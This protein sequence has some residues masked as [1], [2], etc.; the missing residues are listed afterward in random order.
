[1]G[2]VFFKI[3]MRNQENKATNLPRQILATQQKSTP[4]EVPIW[5]L[6]SVQGV[7]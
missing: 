5:G 1:M 2:I 3:Y 7:L 6:T 4:I